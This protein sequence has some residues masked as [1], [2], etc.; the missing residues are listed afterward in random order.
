MAKKKAES[1]GDHATGNAVPAECRPRL[2]RLSIRNFRCIGTAAVDVEVDDIVVLVGPNNVGKSAIL[3]VYELLMSEGSAK[4]YLQLGDF[5][6]EKVDVAHLPTV[7]LETVVHADYQPGEKWVAKDEGSG[8][9]VVKERWCWQGENQAPTRVGWDVALG[10]WHPSE[11]PWGAA[12]VAQAGRPQAHRVRAF[13]DP[14]TQ[15][16]EIVSLLETALEERVKNLRGG[17]GDAV[18]LYQKLLGNIG[19]LQTAIAA[20]AKT[21]VAGI[22]KELT[23]FVQKVFPGYQVM[24]DARPEADLEK[25]VKLFEGDAKLRMGPADGHTPSIDRQ[26]SGA[27]RTLLW[28]ALKILSEH[29]QAADKKSGGRPHVLLLDEPELC[30]HPN[31]IRD[32]CKVLYDLPAGGNWQVM[33]TTHSPV[34]IDLARDNT[35][36]VRVER[37]LDGNVTGTTIYRPKRAHLGA[38][39]KERLKLLNVF[40]P[41]VAEFFFGGRTV[42]VE[43][44]TE[45]TAFKY[46][47][48]TCPEEFRDIHIVRARGKATIV[49]I[50]KILNQFGSDYSV[51]HDSDSKE[52]VSKKTGKKMANPAWAINQSILDVVGAVPAGRSVRLLASV[53]NFEEAY[54]GEAVKDEKPYTALERLRTAAGEEFERV[55]DLLKALV[56]SKSE[57]PHGAVAWSTIGMLEKALGAKEP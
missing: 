1:E 20:G 10:D 27:R 23:E 50:C 47:M 15:A 16:K 19:E 14:E 56:D 40:D 36:I 34:F 13:Q 37:R 52:I 45:Y 43:G 33:V 26:G 9:L 5:P 38:D 57:P 17:A 46:V 2:R 4:G 11:R 31:A 6:N 54:F 42:V 12:N 22:E 18:S 49:S 8:E 24:L 30:L 55:R 25:C 48:L 41:Y 53:P 29:K 32:A 35:S 39:D 51:L 21:E 28:S 44:D 7:E 3:R